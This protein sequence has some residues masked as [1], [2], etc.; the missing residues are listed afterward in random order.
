[1]RLD[2]A[3]RAAEDLRHRLLSSLHIAQD[4]AGAQALGQRVNMKLNTRNFLLFQTVLAVVSSDEVAVS[5]A[6]PLRSSLAGMVY[7]ERR[8]PVGAQVVRARFVAIR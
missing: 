7:P 4:E 5:S 3:N 6:S 8:R 1:V 2:R